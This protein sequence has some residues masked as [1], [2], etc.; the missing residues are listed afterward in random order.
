MSLKCF[1]LFS[2]KEG[3]IPNEVLLTF[4][5]VDENDTKPVQ[6]YDLV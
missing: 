6:N 4:L 3:V 2:T 5:S 1:Q